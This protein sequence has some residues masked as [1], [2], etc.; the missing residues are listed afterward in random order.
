[1]NFHRPLMITLGTIMVLCGFSS[2]ADALLASVKTF[3]MAAT[4]VAYPQDALVGAFNPAGHAEIG[5]RL[6]A[7]I[8]WAHDTGHTRIKG[9]LNPSL[10]G[11]YK[12]FKT[13]DFYVP[14][15]GINKSFGCDCNWALGFIVYNR[16]FNKTTYNRPFVLLG[17]SNAGS[18]YLHQTVSPVLA[19]KIN[20]CHSVGI[21]VNYQVQ[22]LKV[23]GLQNFDNALRSVSPGKVTN[24]GYDWSTGWG[25]TIGWLWH[26]M[27]ELTFGL[28]YQPETEM[29]DFKKYK[30]FVA[31]KGDFNIPTS[32]STG[33]AWR[34]M[35]CATIAF[36][37]Q[38]YAWKDID[39]LHN[40]L[41][42]DGVLE[43][44]G[45]KHGP[46]FGFR[47]QFYYRLGIDYAL[48]DNLTIRAGYRT[49]NGPVRRS[50]TVVNILTQDVVNNFLTVGA[51]YI[52]DEC[53]EFSTFFAYGF[54]N[55]IKGKDSIPAAFGG[56][57]ADLT[58][59]KFAF[60]LSWGLNY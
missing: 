28:T 60:G 54:E 20:D 29:R 23:N 21:S 50:Q 8:T 35:E 38:Y 47:S 53:N 18:E 32:V 10:N 9:N 55:K 14:D 2:S 42:H 26:I 59:R 44:L 11:K 57:E 41:L 45:S 12:A 51:T 17:T 49:T 52:W 16:N 5:D 46:G 31:H 1:M 24:R 48:M 43:L 40:P 58:A 27:P 37:V 34:F 39:S 15:F 7:G 13:K 36:D 19:Y 33:L 25:V 6:D 30:G 4:G 3:G 22:R 56:G